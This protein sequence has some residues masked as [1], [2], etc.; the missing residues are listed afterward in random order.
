M[1]QGDL[2]DAVA[3]AFCEQHNLP[4]AA[5]RSLALRLQAALGSQAPAV[6]PSPAL[7]PGRGATSRTAGTDRLY[8]QGLAARRQHERVAA[9]CRAAREAAALEEC[10][11]PVITALAMALPRAEP[12]WQRLSALAAGPEREVAL[13]RARLLE[14]EKVRAGSGLSRL[15]AYALVPRSGARG[16][17]ICACALRAF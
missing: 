12:A 10:R 8:R 6:G 14:A 5:V 4:S 13:Y 7:Q 1:R 11:E 15:A 9:E 16:M 17:H 2:P 3:A